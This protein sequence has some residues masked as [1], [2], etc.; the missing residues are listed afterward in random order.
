MVI[1]PLC[2]EKTS[3]LALVWAVLEPSSRGWR[4]VVMTAKPVAGVNVCAASRSQ[5]LRPKRRRKLA[6]H[7][8]LVGD[9]LDHPEAHDETRTI[10]P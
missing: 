1:G 2:R 7:L 10:H 5:L 4:G 3:A 9:V 8:L 6:D